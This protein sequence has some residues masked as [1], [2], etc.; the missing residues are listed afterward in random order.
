MIWYSSSANRVEGTGLFTH[1][2]GIKSSNSASIAVPFPTSMVWQWIARYVP[3][4]NSF[5]F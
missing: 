3:Y 5:S 4:R 1:A 2:M